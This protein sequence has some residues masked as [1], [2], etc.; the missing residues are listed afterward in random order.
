MARNDPG[1][2]R[3]TEA[4]RS[5][6]DD[7]AARQRRYLASMAVR[8]ACFVLAVVFRETTPLMV[9]FIVAAFLLPSIAVVFANAQG[10]SD[11]EPVSG[12]AYDP[13]RKAIEPPPAG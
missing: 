10:S 6:S 1:A 9:A 2:F 13:A 5:H 12:T 11:H 3:I 4:T 8:T 7:I